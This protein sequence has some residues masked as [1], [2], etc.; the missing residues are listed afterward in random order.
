M[1]NTIKPI[2]I[3]GVLVAGMSSAS[4]ELVVPGFMNDF[5]AGDSSGWTIAERPQVGDGATRPEVKNELNGNKYLEYTS[6]GSRNSS[7]NRRV[8]F[9]NKTTWAGDYSDIDA[10]TGRVFATSPT[11]DFIYL[12]LGFHGNDD[13]YYSSKDPFQV[14]TDGEWNDFSF[15]L[16]SSDYYV[17]GPGQWDAW[18]GSTFVASEEGSFQ[19]AI[20]NIHEFKFVSNKAYPQWGS[21]DAIAATVGVDDITANVSA[22]PV[23][24]AAW[25]MV[26]GLLGLAGMSSRKGVKA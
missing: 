2:A 12:R 5:E 7:A 17:Q 24:G 15:S 13:L 1:R 23:P 4:A 21:V 18:K 9:Y 14:A 3:A 25:L 8:A 26:S 20:S 16:K 11:E 22:V 19:A 6:T 10:I